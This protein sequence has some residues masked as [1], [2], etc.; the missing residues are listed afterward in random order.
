MPYLQ[1]GDYARLRIIS[2]EPGDGLLKHAWPRACKPIEMEFRRPDPN[3]LRAR[4]WFAVRWLAG[5][6]REKAGARLDAMRAEQYPGVEEF[7]G[8][9]DYEV[10]T[11]GS[12]GT[13]T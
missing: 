11:P 2:A 10:I 7:W 5:V 12:G 6:A 4:F 13:G 9:V 3:G 8:H 1:P